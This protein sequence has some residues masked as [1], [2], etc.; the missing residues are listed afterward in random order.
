[1]KERQAFAK[2]KELT[3][4]LLNAPPSVNPRFR[5]IDVLE[6]LLGDMTSVLNGHKA[7]ALADMVKEER[8]NAR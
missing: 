8:E 4:E 6:A 2:L 1:M 5:N 3:D 7:S